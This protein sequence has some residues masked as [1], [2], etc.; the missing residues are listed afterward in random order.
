MTQSSMDMGKNKLPDGW[1]WVKLGDV[2]KEDRTT[3]SGNGNRAKVLPYLGLEHIESGTG[4]ILVT[5]Q[6]V[7]EHSGRSNTF[8]FDE[9]HILYGKLRPYL[10]KVALPSYSHNR[11]HPFVAK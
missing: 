9:R 5:P 8:A 1:K 10:N 7:P 3:V 4:R 6:D 2:C 11:G